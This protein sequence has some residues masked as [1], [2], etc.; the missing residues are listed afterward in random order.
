VNNI[1]VLDSINSKVNSS[2]LNKS[3]VGLDAEI[4]FT[5]PRGDQFNNDHAHYYGTSNKNIIIIS[6]HYRGFDQRAIILSHGKEIAV[7]HSIISNGCIAALY[8]IDAIS[9]YIPGVLG[10]NESLQQ[11][12]NDNFIEHDLYTQPRVYKELEVPSVLLSGNHKNIQEWKDT[13]LKK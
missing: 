4:L 13:F 10:N 3:L 12:T 8:I 6:G 1:N 2:S 9:R 7:G 11:E 5:S